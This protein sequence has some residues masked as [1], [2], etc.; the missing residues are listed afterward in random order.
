MYPVDTHCTWHITSEQP[1]TVVIEFTQFQLEQDFDFLTIGEG[2]NVS[3]VGK[4]L[5][6][7]GD[8]APNK[9]II[10]NTE[11]AWMTFLSDVLFPDFGFALL[12]TVKAIIGKIETVVLPNS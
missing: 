4:I 2:R 7:T 5:G 3:G 10:L 11:S 6:L 9:I 8:W 12:I 1:G